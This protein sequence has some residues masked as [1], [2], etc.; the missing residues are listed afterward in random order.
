MNT[1]HST[2]C[3]YA[4]RPISRAATMR[5]TAHAVRDFQPAWNSST[6]A[7]M[8]AAMM[9]ATTIW[10][11]TYSTVVV[12]GVASGVTTVTLVP[13]GSTGAAVGV[14]LARP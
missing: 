8:P 2:S 12:F 5:T 11:A 14:L 7:R 6:R 4:N 3:I 1:S 13:W 10:P 9:R